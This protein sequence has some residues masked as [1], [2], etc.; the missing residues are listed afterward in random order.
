MKCPMCGSDAVVVYASVRFEWR[1]ATKSWL[2]FEWKPEPEIWFAVDRIEVEDSTR[3][4]CECG[5]SG[6]AN[7]LEES[8]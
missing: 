8:E 2:M 4:E 1:E 7:E 6:E 3:A 5:W